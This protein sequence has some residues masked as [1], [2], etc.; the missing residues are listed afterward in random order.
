MAIVYHLNCFW[1]VFVFLHA[2]AYFAPNAY[3]LPFN[4]YI[5][6]LPIDGFLFAWELNYLIITVAMSFGGMSIVFFVL[7]PFILMN[8][9]CWWLDIALLTAETINEGLLTDKDICNSERIA[10]TTEK[11]KTFAERCEKFVDWQ[12]GA[13]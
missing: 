10:K 8:Q 11:L 12:S 5:I 6:V 3:H 4:C 13:Q 1:I 9:S 7:L 2:L